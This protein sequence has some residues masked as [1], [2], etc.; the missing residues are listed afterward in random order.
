MD[1]N[2]EQSVEIFT[3]VEI[4]VIGMAG[5]FPGARNTSEFWRNLR[6]GVESVTFSAR[7]SLASRAN[8]QEGL[9]DP[10]YVKAHS[11]Y[12][13]TWTASMLVFWL[14]AARRRDYGPPTSHLSGG[15]GSAED[16]GHDS[17]AFPGHIGVFAACGM[18]TYMMYHLVTNRRLSDTVGEWL[19]RHTGNIMNSLA[20][21]L[22]YPMFKGG[23][24]MEEN[25]GEK[26]QKWVVARY[27]Q[28]ILSIMVQIF[29]SS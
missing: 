15:L 6:D 16:A 22:S 14:L 2:A 20:T 23:I 27:F 19:L 29:L 5:R 10:A 11:R 18:N 24:Q 3:G 21:R 26:Y 28:G 4:A 7:R 25:F 9:R 17:E 1:S 8:L 13:P 12:S